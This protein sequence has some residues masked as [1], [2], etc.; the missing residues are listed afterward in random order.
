MEREN[1]RERE[2][3][4]QRDSHRGID[5]KERKRTV[6]TDDVT[7]RQGVREREG[8]GGNLTLIRSEVPSTTRIYKF[9]LLR[10]VCVV[11]ERR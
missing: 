3:S 8:R 9:A 6:V 7:T 2:E 10:M 1:W 5:L 4:R 11:R